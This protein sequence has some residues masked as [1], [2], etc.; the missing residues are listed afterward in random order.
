LAGLIPYARF[1]PAIQDI[2]MDIADR[3]RILKLIGMLGSAFDGERA[4]AAGMLSK[5]AEA[6]KMTLNELIEAAHGAPSQARS[7]PPPPPHPSEPPPETF[8]DIDEADDLLRMLRRI[9]E[10]PD[11]AAR[12]LTSWEINF[13]TD[14]SA[15]Y[16]RDYELSEK[17]LNVVQKILVKAS[18]VFK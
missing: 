8:T 17:Q 4:N 16:D 9:P 18:R 10:R 12:V 7:T 15:R 3:N 2:P 11:I 13:A 14:V 6:R 5:M 1:E